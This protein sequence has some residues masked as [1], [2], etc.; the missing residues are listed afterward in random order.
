MDRMLVVIFN[1][2]SNAY[3]GQKALL[4]LDRE[5]SIGLDAYA[6][7]SKQADGKATIKQG[8]DSGPLGTLLGTTVGSLI[9]ILGGP[10]G[11]AIGAT[12]G[13][14]S[15]SIFDVHNVRVGE[16]FID[17]VSGAL[18]PNKVALVAQIEE[19]WTTPVDARMEAAGG[20]VYRRALSEVTDAVNQEDVA[21]MK[22]DLAQ[23]KAE[24]AEAR[25]DRQAKLQE[26]IQKLDTK[27]QTHLQKIQDRRRAAEKHAKAR[28]ERLKGKAAER[29]SL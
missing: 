6:V 22:A 7:I 26:K 12:V 23:Y 15:G 25:A 24:V 2:E 19:E 16:D 27:I 4:Q 11:L 18:T 9:G 5:G 8:A 14:T 20:T 3:E 28:A 21:A 13:A 10:A 29:P 1:N 17:D